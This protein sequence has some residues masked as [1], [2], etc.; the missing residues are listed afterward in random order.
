MQLDEADNVP[1]GRLGSRSDADATIHTGGA[2]STFGAS[3]PPLTSS[4]RA[5]GI[6]DEQ[7]QDKGSNTTIG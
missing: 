1:Y 3:S 5:K 7:G 2:P 4:F 6:T